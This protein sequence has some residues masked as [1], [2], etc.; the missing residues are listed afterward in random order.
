MDFVWKTYGWFARKTQVNAANGGF[1]K[2]WR[3]HIET[4]LPVFRLRANGKS[5]AWCFKQSSKRSTETGGYKV[6]NGYHSGQKT[7]IGHTVN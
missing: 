2:A 3:P 7:A 6:S 4:P 5:A 1:M